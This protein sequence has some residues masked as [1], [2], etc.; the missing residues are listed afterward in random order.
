MKI[1]LTSAA[2]SHQVGIT[3]INSPTGRER[4]RG[5]KRSERREVGWGGCWVGEGV[6]AEWGGGRKVPYNGGGGKA[7][8]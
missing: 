3:L 5:V 8:G 6:R 2:Q 7:A 4:E 1:I